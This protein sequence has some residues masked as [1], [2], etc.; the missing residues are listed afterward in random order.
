MAL[1]R[2]DP[3]FPVDSEG[4]RACSVCDGSVALPEP[5]PWIQF[6]DVRV[7]GFGAGMRRS[8]EADEDEEMEGHPLLSGPVVH[9]A[10]LQAWVDA[11]FAE[12]AVL[13]REMQ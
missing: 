5:Q 4:F 7:G 11:L 6:N 12:S 3:C 9:V 2:L 13:T 10:C 1:E 8:W